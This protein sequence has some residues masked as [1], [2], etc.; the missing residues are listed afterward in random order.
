MACA[1]FCLD[2]IR[3]Q[4]KLV[5]HRLATQPKSTQLERRQFVAMAT[6]K[7]I[8]YRIKSARF[9]KMAAF[10]LLTC[11]YILAIA[12]NFFFCDLRVVPRKL[13]SPF[14]H[15]TQ[16]SRLDK[17]EVCVTVIS[18]SDRTHVGNILGT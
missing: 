1:H 6:Y 12:L 5:V 10:C 16:V 11:D 15:P 4:A 2:Q 18:Q 13:A 7:P 8:K 17:R 3:T 9:F 14:A